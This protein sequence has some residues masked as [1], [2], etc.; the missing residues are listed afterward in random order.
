MSAA[1]NKTITLLILAS[2]LLLGSCAS[3][4][5][6][7]GWL[8][9]RDQVAADPYGGWI[10][11]RLGQASHEAIVQGEYIGTTDSAA[12]VLTDYGMVR[13]P[14]DRVLSI[15]LRIHDVAT[16]EMATWGG[17][18]TVSTL[19][20]GW[21]LVFTAPAWVGMWIG[22]SNA[23]SAAGHF[24]YYR[25]ADL[26]DQSGNSSTRIWLQSK[27][28]YARFPQG[29]PKGIRLDKLEPKHYLHRDE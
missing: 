2:S 17:F 13:V 18:G 26:A 7:R 27:S 29:I 9:K 16:G 24:S 22:T 1:I 12:Y 28:E 15:E 14:Y 6:P 25:D 11:L 3:Y 20:H 21:W 23:E 8:P 19:T 10:Y 4:R 5:V